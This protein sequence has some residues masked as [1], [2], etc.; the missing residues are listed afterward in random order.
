MTEQRLPAMW[1]WADN[2]CPWCDV[3]AARLHATAPEYRDRVKLRSRA[4]PLEILDHDPAPRGI[5]EQEWWLAAIQEPAAAFA[6]YP[7]DAW[8]TTTLPAFG[9]AWA[10]GRQGDDVRLDVDLRGRRAFFAE[11]RTIGRRKVLCEIAEEAGSDLPRFAHDVASGRALP[12]VL[13]EARLGREQCRVRGTPTRMLADG[14]RLRHPIA[15]P[16]MRDRNINGVA[17][18]PCHGE[19]CPAATRDLFES[20][21]RQCATRNEELS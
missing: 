12:A 13:E 17:A 6:P 9:A 5:L 15:S 2:D 8:P 7:S 4:Y 18:L 14:T 19:A 1:E 16:R 10:A 11:G 21:L 20:A 3:G